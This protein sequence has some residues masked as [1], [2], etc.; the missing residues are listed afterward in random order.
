MTTASV[1]FE[2]RKFAISF[3]KAKVTAV[4]TNITINVRTLEAE[5]SA[6]C[7]I[8]SLNRRTDR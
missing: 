1:K 4:V 3:A 6:E 8:T 5:T 7:A 2:L